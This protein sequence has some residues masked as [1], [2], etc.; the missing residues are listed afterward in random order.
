MRGVGGTSHL[1]K[2]INLDLVFLLQFMVGNVIFSLF[3]L[4]FHGVLG[5]PGV[6]RTSDIISMMEFSPGMR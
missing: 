6:V 2:I 3:G 1:E 5:L 4:P